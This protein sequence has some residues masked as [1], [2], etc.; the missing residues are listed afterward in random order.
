MVLLAGPFLAS[1]TGASLGLL[2]PGKPLKHK[3]LDSARADVFRRF[4]WCV[5]QCIYM[6]ILY[7]VIS[8][9][10][11]N[12]MEFVWISYVLLFEN[13]WDV[14]WKSNCSWSWFSSCMWQTLFPDIKDGCW[15][16]S[17]GSSSLVAIHHCS[18]WEYYAISHA[19]II[20]I[21]NYI[22][23]IYT[24]EDDSISFYHQFVIVPVRSSTLWRN[25]LTAGSIKNHHFMGI[26]N[27]L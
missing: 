10:M 6:Y 17:I 4:L 3:P 14:H 12:P 13:V 5:Q 2:Q 21:Y 9:A 18:S 24:Y 25:C 23:Y 20:Y 8:H 15:K 1:S 11:Q 26:M 27:H 19:C 7:T 22:I 16:S